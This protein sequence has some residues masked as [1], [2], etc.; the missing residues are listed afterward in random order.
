M[1]LYFHLTDNLFHCVYTALITL[2]DSGSVLFSSRTFAWFNLFLL[3]SVV[4]FQ[5]AETCFCFSP[6]NIVS[7][8]ISSMCLVI[9]ASGVPTCWHIFCFHLCYLVSFF[10]GISFHFCPG[11]WTW[12]I[13]RMAHFSSR[14]WFCCLLFSFSNNCSTEVLLEYLNPMQGWNFPCH[15]DDLELSDH[16]HGAWC[17]FFFFWCSSF[18][19]SVEDQKICQGPAHTKWAFDTRRIALCAN[20]T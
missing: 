10:T 20:K 13:V 12:N 4:L 1:F 7:M 2:L 14:E 17:A 19:S 5:N 9:P 3:L 11:H 15:S 6:V 18:W 16:T 8:V